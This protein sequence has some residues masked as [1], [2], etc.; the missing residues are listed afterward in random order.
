MRGFAQHTAPTGK[1]IQFQWTADCQEAFE[2][3]KDTL[4][5]MSHPDFTQHF[6]LYKDASQ[7]AVGAVL[8]QVVDTLEKVVANASHSFTAAKRQWFTYNRELW[9]IVWAVRSFRHYLGLLPFIFVT[10]H[11]LLLGP[12]TTPY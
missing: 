7:V 11:L 8:A 12:T 3:L 1:D 4:C 10:D 9:A 2:F 6:T 5:C